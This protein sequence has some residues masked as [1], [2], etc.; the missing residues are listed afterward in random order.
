[1]DLKLEIQYLKKIE[2]NE[3]TSPDIEAVAPEI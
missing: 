1:M 2:F 3:S